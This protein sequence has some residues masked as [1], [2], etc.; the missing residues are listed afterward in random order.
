MKRYFIVFYMQGQSTFGYAGVD[1]DDGLIF[2]AAHFTASIQ[3]MQPN[4][5]KVTIRSFNE[6]TAEEYEKF[7]AK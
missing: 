4:L 5:G 2:N 7:F 3:K 6:V 1:T